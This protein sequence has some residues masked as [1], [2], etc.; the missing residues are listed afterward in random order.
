[1]SLQIFD[2][3]AREKRVFQPLEAEKIGIY[4]CGMTVY[5]HCHLG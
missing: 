3:L 4:V 5:D 2:T 1:M